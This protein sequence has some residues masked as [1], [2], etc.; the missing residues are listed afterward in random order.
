MSPVVYGRNRDGSNIYH[1]AGTR[2][3]GEGCGHR[4]QTYGA[5][6]GV[7]RRMAMR[8]RL[9]RQAREREKAQQ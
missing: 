8:K 2:R 7:H 3:D 1:C 4:V 6:C 5:L 9:E